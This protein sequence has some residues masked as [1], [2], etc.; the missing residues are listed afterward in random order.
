MSDVLRFP[1]QPRPV[2]P[3]TPGMG[4]GDSAATM[5]LSRPYVLPPENA[6]NHLR[7][8]Q[9]ILDGLRRY[10]QHTPFAETAKEVLVYVDGLE[11]R[12]QKALNQ[13]EAP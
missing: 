7:N 10:C 11:S 4:G 6:A 8:A 5:D 1:P 3:H 12:I 9:A 13:I 2:P